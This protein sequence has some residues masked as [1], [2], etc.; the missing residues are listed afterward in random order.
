MPFSPLQLLFFVVIVACL[1]VFIQLSALTLAFYKLGLSEDSAFLLLAASLLGSFVNLPLLTL[2]PPIPIALEQFRHGFLIRVRR[3]PADR[4]IIA[5]NVGGCLIPVFFSL[6]LLAQNPINPLNLIL[7]IIVVTSV[8]Y[9]LSRPIKGVGIGMPM[10]VAPVTAALIAVVIGDE[11][12]AAMAYISGILGV[13]IGADILH[14]R[15]VLKIG[16]PVA[17]IGGAGTFDGIFIT[18]LI[19]VLLT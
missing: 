18:G 11:Q 14:I 5:V 16:A 10:L 2:R 6:Y 1:V 7:A 12:R 15:D 8:S 4:M 17:S 19:A 9:L 13:L 3:W